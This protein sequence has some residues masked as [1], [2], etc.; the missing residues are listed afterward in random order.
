MNK[1][2][3]TVCSNK[4]IADDIYQMVL[5]GELAK[6]CNAPGQFLH[7]KVS[8]SVTPLLRRPISIA[9]ID[10]DKEEVTI[11]FR[12]SGEGTSL[13]AAKTKGDLLDVLGP[14]GNGFPVET[15]DSG[16][17]A[18]LVG[19]GIGVPPLY[20]H[21]KQL[22]NKKVDIISVLGFQS[23]KDVF[24]EQEFNQYG[25][26][27]IATVDGT[28]GTKGYVTDVI[29]A[30]KLQFDYLF[31]CGPTPMLKALKDR[32]P[33]KEVYLSLEERMG[34]GIGACLACVCHTDESDQSYMKVCVD[35]PV[36]RAQEV[37]L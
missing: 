24:Y 4:R 11:I 19:G 36:F 21:A 26:V 25:S 5:R 22:T 9:H 32:Y 10:Q 27:H 28:H 12:K 31:A 3:M 14:L 20:E 8:E 29:E 37:L 30:E 15:I 7:L 17:T 34:C 18:L 2:Y 35:G 33:D 16:K 13:L 1:G 23:V 6:T